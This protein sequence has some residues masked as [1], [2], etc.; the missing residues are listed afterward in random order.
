MKKLSLTITLLAITLLTHAQVPNAR[1]FGIENNMVW[2]FVPGVEI[3]TAK[4]TTTIFQSDKMRGELLTGILFRPGTKNDPN[5][6]VFKEIGL[7]LGYRHYF[8][9]GFHLEFML[10][11]SYAQ[12]INNTIDGQDYKS[13]A[14]T[15]ELYTGYKFNLF[16]REK[17]NLYL[18]PQVGVGY[19]VFSRLGPESEANAPFPVISLQLGVNF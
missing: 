6:E 13:L 12:E 9:E 8:T 7:G 11:P 5:A 10:F 19:N 4:L 17:Y 16:H 18:L 2:P 14:M 15:T 3:Y 1:K